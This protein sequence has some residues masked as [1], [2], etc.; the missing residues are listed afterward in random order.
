MISH[1]YLLALLVIM[2]FL[3][4]TVLWKLQIALFMLHLRRALFYPSIRLEIGLNVP[5]LTSTF[6]RLEIH[7]V[8]ENLVYEM[9][10]DIFLLLCI[11]AA[12][13]SAAFFVITC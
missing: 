2:S 12:Q 8:E 9:C 11:H 5:V 7:C 1:G 3:A 4:V 13:L 6:Y 10:M